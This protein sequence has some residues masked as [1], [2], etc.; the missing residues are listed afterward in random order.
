MMLIGSEFIAHAKRPTLFGLLPH[1][2]SLYSLTQR[3]QRP[4][5]CFTPWVRPVFTILTVLVTF[6]DGNRYP[7]YAV[8]LSTVMAEQATPPHRRVS[9]GL[10]HDL[11]GGFFPLFSSLFSLFPFLIL[12]GPQHRLH[13]PAH[14]VGHLVKRFSVASP[15]V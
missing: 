12:Y 14:Y 3:E 9:F 11:P 7:F 6:Y 15:S 5:I 4:S 1:S 8:L 10:L 13:R 2:I